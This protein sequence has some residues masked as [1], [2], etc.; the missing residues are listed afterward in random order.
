MFLGIIDIRNTRGVVKELR[1]KVIDVLMK[2]DL[3]DRFS[4]RVEVTDNRI[5]KCQ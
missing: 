2:L 5:Q 3:T 1:R 4:R